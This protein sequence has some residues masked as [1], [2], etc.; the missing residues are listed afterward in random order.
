MP[1]PIANN[2]VRNDSPNF[3]AEQLN[4]WAE[5]L[6]PLMSVLRQMIISAILVVSF[7]LTTGTRIQ[8][9]SENVEGCPDAFDT[10]PCHSYAYSSESFEAIVQICS[11]VP[12]ASGCQLAHHHCSDEDH[13]TDICF[14]LNVLLSVCTEFEGLALCARFEE[15]CGPLTNLGACDGVTNL[16]LPLTADV[17][18]AATSICSQNDLD[19]CTECLPTEANP[20]K[21]RDPFIFAGK[22]KNPLNTL[23]ALCK[24]THAPECRLIEN[25]CHAMRFDNSELCQLH[26]ANRTF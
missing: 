16:K 24:V 11:M 2:N 9:I 6:F 12:F 20:A 26:T 10:E 22:C 17:Y 14:P 19:H 3:H 23:A 13:D 21:N 8:N 18:D 5:I 4:D 7:T 1:A 25:W 15:L